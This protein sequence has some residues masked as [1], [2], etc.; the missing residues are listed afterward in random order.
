VDKIILNEDLSINYSKVTDLIIHRYFRDLDIYYTRQCLDRNKSTRPAKDVI[1]E[2]FIRMLRKYRRKKILL[3]AHSMGSIIA[4]DV[5]I[6]SAPDVKIHTLVTIGS[7]LGFPPIRIKILAEQHREPKKHITLRTPESIVTAWLNFSDLNDKVATPYKLS[8]DYEENSR[9]VRPI[10]AIVTNIY[11][12]QGNPNPHCVYGYL[13]TPEVSHVI[14]DFLNA[15]R[16]KVLTWLN[17]NINY[18]LDKV[19]GNKGGVP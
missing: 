6:R 13:R 14:R 2:E 15:G 11:E 1:R 7:P 9:H 8:D 4:Y 5:L 19:R 3:I 10:D 18:V 17:D 12:Y 16:P